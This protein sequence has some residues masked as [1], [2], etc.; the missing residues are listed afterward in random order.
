MHDEVV[1]G[2]LCIGAPVPKPE[3]AANQARIRGLCLGVVEAD[4]RERS[5]AEIVDQDIGL[6]SEVGQRV[7]AIDTVEVQRTTFLVAV[8]WDAGV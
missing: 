3:I 6:A 5:R 7:L 1:A 4:A 2:S 8:D